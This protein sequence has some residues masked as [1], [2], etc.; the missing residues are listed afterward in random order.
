MKKKVALLLVLVMILSALPMNVFGNAVWTFPGATVDGGFEDRH[1]TREFTVRLPLSSFWTQLSQQQA[2]ANPNFLRTVMTL[3]YAGIDLDGT[4]GGLGTTLANLLANGHTIVPSL[5]NTTGNVTLA[6]GTT[7]RRAIEGLSVTLTGVA[8]GHAGST[9]F[10]QGVFEIQHHPVHNEGRQALAYTGVTGYIEFTI[11]LRS[12]WGDW[13][14]STLTLSGQTGHGETHVHRLIDRWNLVWSVP[15]CINVTVSGARGFNSALH[16]NPIRVSETHFGRIDAVGDVITLVLDAPAFYTFSFG[17]NR[18]PNND[19][20]DPNSTR[21]PVNDLLP[22]GTTAITPGRPGTLYPMWVRATGSLQG[23]TIQ[24]VRSMRA[25]GV[26]GRHRLEIDVTVANIPGLRPLTGAFYIDNLWLTPDYNAPTTGNVYVDARVGYRTVGTPGHGGQTGV[27]GQWVYET[28]QLPTFN[29]NIANPAADANVLAAAASF[30]IVPIAPATTLTAAQLVELRWH[31]FSAGVV[32]T[33]IQGAVNNSIWARN[34]AGANTEWVELTPALWNAS[35]A[36]GTATGAVHSQNLYDG[37][38]EFGTTTLVTLPPVAP[39]PIVQ[40]RMWTLSETLR[41]DAPT[42][43]N[44][45]DWFFDNGEWAP[46]DHQYAVRRWKATGDAFQFSPILGAATRRVWWHGQPHVDAVNPVA[47]GINFISLCDNRNYVTLHVGTRGAAGLQAGVYNIPYMRTGHLGLFR[48][49]ACFFEVG[50][51]CLFPAAFNNGIA[52]PTSGN[53][54]LHIDY[55]M[56]RNVPWNRDNGGVPHFTG[57]ATGSLIIEETIAGAFATGF[58]SPI[59]FDFLDADGNPHPGIQIL[60]VQARAGNN[61][62]ARYRTWYNNGF[63]GFHSGT[64]GFANNYERQN[65]MTF[66]GW[67]G[68]L[69]QRLPV[70]PGVGRLSAER[71]TIYLPTQSITDRAPGA[72]EIRFFLSLEAGFEWKYGRNVDVT[73]SGSGVYHLAAADRVQT[74]GYAI[75]P[76]AANFTAVEIE[77][78]TLYNVANQALENV[79]VEVVNPNAFQIGHELWVYISE[80]SGPSPSSSLSFA[81]TPVLTVANSSMRFSH[82]QR[83]GDRFVFTVVQAPTRNEEPTLTLSGLRVSGIAYPEVD[84]SIV[85]S[86]TGIAN[87]DMAVFMHAWSGQG[88]PAQLRSLSRGV[89][90]TLPYYATALT[91]AG[92]GRWEGAPTGDTPTNQ[93]PQNLEFRLQE[94]VPFGG[95]AEPL[96]WHIVGP[97]RVGMVSMR[98]FAVMIGSDPEEEIVWDS[99]TRVAEVRGRHHNGHQVGIAVQMGNTN[100]T[101][102]Q[103][104][105]SPQTV[106][107]ATAVN[108]LSGPAG[109]VEP[110]NVNN[111]VYLPLRFMAETFGF[112]VERQGNIVIFR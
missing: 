3:Q 90:S 55:P 64:A 13:Q 98:A 45:E 8:D 9:I 111:H 29:T 46:V 15:G 101:V 48:A 94:G 52:N 31:A 37:S 49:P 89:F 56:T 87:N 19:G 88:A 93:P 7:T 72:L 59:H 80:D 28:V 5:I 18:G 109:T 34:T 36:D 107:I 71:A 106:D 65:W 26:A 78:G 39:Y 99:A 97:N 96:I 82:G 41:P 30:G 81:G 60:G 84:Y 57:V 23:A 38:V 16:L 1:Q 6:D 35:W 43:R 42:N 2:V 77:G 50:N 75:D 103:G 108:F 104:T 91:N 11:P 20:V 24:R 67:L 32:V 51:T 100:A 74:I 68:A 47:P 102:V 112:T 62:I 53:H 4:R 86:G 14:R 85:V 92:E 110:L 58:G 44:R 69:D 12:Y 54:N 33:A 22:A 10:R 95:V 105:G 73:I 61:Y 83:D 17:N 25:P 63:R 76:I 70:V 66:A 27:P 79:V 21:F 40:R